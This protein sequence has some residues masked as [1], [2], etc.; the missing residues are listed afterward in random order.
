MRISDRT[1]VRKKQG[2]RD[3]EKIGHRLDIKVRGEEILNE[4]FSYIPVGEIGG[5]AAELMEEGSLS[6]AFPMLLVLPDKYDYPE[7]SDSDGKNDGDEEYPRCSRKKHILNR[8]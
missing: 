3:R 4:Y 2:F 5:S 1:S 6:E 7:D 8:R